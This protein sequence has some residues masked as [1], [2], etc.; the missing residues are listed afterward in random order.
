MKLRQMAY[1]N[2]KHNLRKYVMY[3]LSLCFSVFTVYAFLGLMFNDAVELIF[4]SDMRYRVILL[5]FGVIIV[6]FVFFFML[7]ANNSFIRARKKEISMYSLFGMP[8]GKIGKL[9]FIETLMV[10]ITALIAGIGLGIFF[11]KLTAM[12][13]LNMI[14]PDYVGTVAFS[15]SVPSVFITASVFIGIFCVLGLGGLFI[16]NRFELVDLFKGDKTSEGN[17][18]GSWILLAVSLG[19]IGYGY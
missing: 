17:P 13:L 9:L 15:V 2:I 14:V 4:Q 8:N 12:I 7:N 5:S 18:K 3:F 19:L 16:I 11:S 1:S 6:V 10:G